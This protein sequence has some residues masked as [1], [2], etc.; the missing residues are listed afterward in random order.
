VIG[1]IHGINS[2]SKIIVTTDDVV[3][4]G[5]SHSKDDASILKSP[6]GAASKEVS[7]K[8]SPR[9]VWHCLTQT[10]NQRLSRNFY[11]GFMKVPLVNK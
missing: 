10:V 11:S 4:R 6:I 8:P 7:S 9:F 2:L 5:A 1:R 3:V